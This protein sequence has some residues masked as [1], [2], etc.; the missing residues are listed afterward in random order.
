MDFLYRI[1]KAA[2]TDYDGTILKEL[3]EYDNNGFLRSIRFESGDIEK[4]HNY[5]YNSD[6][7]LA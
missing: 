6:G 4:I 2:F 1:F 7:L 5:F 3:Y